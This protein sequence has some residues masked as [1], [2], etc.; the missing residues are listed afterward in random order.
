M[1]KLLALL[2]LLVSIVLYSC[3]QEHPCADNPTIIAIDSTT[4]FASNDISNPNNDPWQNNLSITYKNPNAPNAQFRIYEVVKIGND[5][6]E[7]F[8][9]SVAA[10]T[11]GSGTGQIVLP[12][13]T[14][15]QYYVLK[16]YGY[17]QYG[18]TTCGGP[19]VFQICPPNPTVVGGVV[20]FLVQIPTGEYVYDFQ[21]TYKNP[22]RYNSN[23]TTR[24]P[25]L[26]L[27]EIVN[28]IEEFRGEALVPYT[29][30]G[31]E[32][33]Y[34]QLSAIHMKNSTFSARI[35][36]ATVSFTCEPSHLLFEG[37]PAGTRVEKP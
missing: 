6:T 29:G 15:N 23:D 3:T 19:T 8:L 7:V 13:S 22:T 18:N 1:K 32:T 5:I 26:K 10:P 24:R 35:D 25:K 20:A 16:I 27:Y 36:C 2:T 14:A 31:D 30:D 11:T 33:S 4:M 12:F 17:G 37:S 34:V 28:G 9:G 21:F